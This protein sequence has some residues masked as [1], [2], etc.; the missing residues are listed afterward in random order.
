LLILVV[1]IVRNAIGHKWK[2][3]RPFQRQAKK[4]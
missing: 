1:K 4:V 3:R 2:N